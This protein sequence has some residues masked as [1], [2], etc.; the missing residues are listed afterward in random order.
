MHHGLVDLHFLD[1]S[2]QNLLLRGLI[3]LNVFVKLFAQ[4]QILDLHL[5]VRFPPGMHRHPVL[6]DARLIARGEIN[7]FTHVLQFVVLFPLVVF[8]V[9]GFSLHVRAMNGPLV[10]V[11]ALQVVHND[12]AHALHDAVCLRKFQ[13]SNSYVERF[14][15][16]TEFNRILAFLIQEHVQIELCVVRGVHHIVVAN[17][18][19]HLSNRVHQFLVLI[20]QLL[21]HHLLLLL[22][23]VILPLEVA[24]HA[25]H[26]VLQSQTHAAIF[27][28]THFI[29][30]R[31]ADGHGVA[32]SIHNQRSSRYLFYNL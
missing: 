17:S 29:Q 4:V 25:R 24:Q 5:F 22:V 7:E 26:H 13:V 27:P 20:Q 21:H 3:L 28:L 19:G 15:K 31:Q 1:E 9:H 12:G 8:Y 6:D 10:H 32:V 30:V 18:W 16:I 23:L 2:F 11:H 14:H